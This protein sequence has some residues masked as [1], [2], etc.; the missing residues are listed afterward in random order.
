MST[1]NSR[2]PEVSGFQMVEKKVGLECIQIVQQDG[3]NH[4]VDYSK[5][6]TLVQISN[7]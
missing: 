3:D 7:G 6:D 5:P 1:A 2:I 4:A